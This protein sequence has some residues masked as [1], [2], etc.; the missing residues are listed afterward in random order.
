MCHLIDGQSVGQPSQEVRGRRC[1]FLSGHAVSESWEDVATA[2]DLH[3]DGRP[4]SAAAYMTVLGARAEDP[5]WSPA[6]GVVW[7]CSTCEEA[8]RDFGLD[9]G[10]PDHRGSGHAVT[11]SRHTADVLAWEALWS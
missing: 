11:C 7:R 4:N 10:G 8:V 2:L 5:W 1:R 9:C 6:Q 3:N